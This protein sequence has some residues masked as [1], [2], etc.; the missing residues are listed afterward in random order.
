MKGLKESTRGE[1][2]GDAN[3]NDGYLNNLYQEYQSRLKAAACIGLG[4]H[5][6]LEIFEVDLNT[7]L[8]EIS[9]DLTI[10]HSGTCTSTILHMVVTGS[11]FSS[12]FRAAEDQF[13]IRGKAEKWK[14]NSE[15]NAFPPVDA[16]R[17]VASCWLSP[18]AVSTLSHCIPSVS[19]SFV[20]ENKHFWLI[21][22]YIKR[23]YSPKVFIPLFRYHHHLLTTKPTLM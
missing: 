4:A 22:R 13:G 11:Q 7:A 12:I 9:A 23:E 3:L 17:F 16:K 19:T 20:E 14:C 1:W 18:K 8:H 15:N 6:T 2:S 10:L 5:G 21:H